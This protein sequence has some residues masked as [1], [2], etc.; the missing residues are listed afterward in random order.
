MI[1]PMKNIRNFS[2]I[3]HID[4]GKSTLADRLL[5][6]TETIP[7]RSMR[8]Q[9]LDS[10][11]IERERGITIKMQ[12]VRMEYSSAGQKYILNLIDTPGHIDFSY[13]VSRALTA[14]EGALL[15][16]DA[17]Q[18]V[19]AQT[20]TTL[21]VAQSLG[22]TIIPV[23]NKIDLASARVSDVRQE[24]AGLLSCDESSILL[25]SGKTGEGI[26][27]L[28]DAIIKRIPAPSPI[29]P[30]SA[31]GTR[32]LIFDFSYSNHRGII[33]YARV[34]DGEIKKG[35]TV[36]FSVGGRVFTTPEVGIFAPAEIPVPVLGT[37]SI[38]YIVTG[39][40]EPQIVRVGDTI[41][42]ARNPLPALIGYREPQPVVWASVFPESQDDFNALTQA[43][44]KL[45]LTDSS[46][47]FEEESSAVL[48][49]G[50][51]C[52]FLGMLHLEIIIERLRREFSLQL[53]VTSPTIAYR[54]T[55][56]SGNSRDVYSPAQFPD[57]PTEVAEP[58]VRVNI[59][60]PPEYLGAI[61]QLAHEHESVIHDTKTLRTKRMELIMEMPL[62]E[63]M[64]GFFDNL[65]SVSSG[66]ASLSYEI[67]EQRRADVLRMDV[68]I[69]NEVIPAFT[70]IV[71][72]R[73]RD[74]E[75]RDI[76]E[77]LGKYIPKHL[78]EFKIQARIDGRIVAS[79]HMSALRKDVTGYLYG[80]DVTRKRKLLE[81]QKKGKKKM[82]GLGKVN[83][84]QDVFIKTMR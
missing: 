12:P 13:E 70:K 17:T 10:M 65:K 28:L 37:G 56:Q 73:R 8:E 55:E 34:F 9:V 41:T 25:V 29:L 16:V 20:L 14:V 64:R 44:L 52:G 72:R 11:D 59:I 35:D 30:L 26:T 61:L 40:K 78:F 32:A 18:G 48:G 76:V 53:I 3:A 50:F 2:I 21:E 63:L 5:E 75:A 39:I 33:V 82:K 57:S 24:L 19:Q 45:R 36:S 38:G 58:W 22:R 46:I 68:L 23:V 81:K 49:R 69:S 42:G 60:T 74:R 1:A 47:V 27:E 83:I 7:P 77:K 15:L 67:I 51:R 80:G 4:H 71:S 66:F 43:L 79:H 6:V 84:P 31:R 62:R 54:V